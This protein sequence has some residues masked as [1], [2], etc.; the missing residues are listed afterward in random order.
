MDPQPSDLRVYSDRESPVLHRLE[1]EVGA[2][3]VDAAFERAYRDLARRVSVRGFRPGKTPRSVLE[4]LYGASL[5]EQVEEALVAETLP[6]AVEQAG[7][8]PVAEPAIEAQAPRAGADFRYTARVEVKPAIELPDLAG[9][10]ARRPRV[11]VGDADVERELE[12]LRQRHAVLIEEA[13][14]AR[15]AEG[16][17]VVL[18]FEGTVDG[19]PFE[20]GRGS[21]VEVE[22]GAGRFLPD[23]ER[24]LLGA[25]S[26]EQREVS[27]EFPADYG[28][29]ELAG[30]RALFATR[31]AAIKRR[32][33][34]AL[35][36]EFAK[37]LGDFA[38]LAQLRA[39]IR[40][41]LAEAHERAARAVL[42]RT[43]LDSLIERTSFAVPPG[44]VERR[45]ANE[46]RAAHDRLAGQVDHDA[47]HQQ[48]DRWREEWRPRAERQV[49]ESLLLEAVA[50]AQ[51]LSAS[52]EDVEAR[53]REIAQ[54]DGV[55]VARL[56]EALGGEA[57]ERALAA[58]LGDEK[59]LEFLAARAKVEESSGT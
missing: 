42:Q 14:E 19:A 34:P 17:V 28:N 48:L 46:L 39:R 5:A 23:F 53:V 18:D 11:E 38:D 31:V 43:L 4:R 47:L 16:H 35:D 59:A 40:S 7:L 45:L 52:P 21:G 12:A 22:V 30:R 58:Q 50:R 13:P 9:L 32:E 41:D 29:A 54:R 25:A 55:S 36:D 24:Q 6:G 1:V 56:R 20:G 49:R 37:D 15:V 3:R 57:L 27:V 2:R 44:M 26:G 8:E 10:P 51:G 33:V